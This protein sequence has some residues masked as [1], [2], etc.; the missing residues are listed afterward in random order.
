M[1]KYIILLAIAT[2]MGMMSCQPDG[3]EQI[4]KETSE[5]PTE[6]TTGDE[7]TTG[8]ETEDEEEPQ[9]PPIV[10]DSINDWKDGSHSSTDLTEK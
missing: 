6:E 3:T 4:T 5:L 8:D 1:R 10:T 7:G 2:S 9:I